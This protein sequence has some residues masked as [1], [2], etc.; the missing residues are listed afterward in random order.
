M[1]TLVLCL[2]LVTTAAHAQYTNSMTGQQ[3]N[4]MWS[5]NAD[6][7]TSRMIQNNMLQSMM[8]A[9]T[10]PQRVAAPKAAPPPKW[11][12]ELAAT[13]FVPTGARTIPEQLAA[14]LPKEDRAQV[15]ELAR[16]ILATLEAQP[17]LRK[18]NLA[19]SIALLLGISLQVVAGGDLT[20]AEG[21][22][23]V[24]LV[25]EVLASDPGF[26]SISAQKRTVTSDT[27]LITGGLIAGIA[28]N[29]KQSGDA[30]QASLARGMA[31]QALGQFGVKVKK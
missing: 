19:T 8:A 31:I 5:A 12:F 2:A 17:T 3:F 29:A 25:N 11:K 28:A 27:F 30:A 14:S 10:Q 18:N 9:K 7:V 16:G 23:L 20:D 13:D 15:V 26:K 6:Y 24:R 1:R 22:Y 4:N 21:E